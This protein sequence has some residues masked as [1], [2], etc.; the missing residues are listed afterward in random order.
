MS[1][2][3][4]MRLANRI[5]KVQP[6]LTL[7][8]AA[9]AKQMKQQGIDLVSFS[10]GEPD[11]DTPE[12]IKQKAIESL[13]SGF[14]KYTPASGTPE[15]K[16]AIAQKLAQENGLNYQPEQIIVSCGAKHSIY[17]VLQVLVNE[18]DEVIFG[19]PYWLSYPEMVTLAGGRSVVIE[20]PLESGY[21]I[22]PEQLESAITPKTKLII[23]NSPSNP[24]GAVYNRDELKALAAIAVKKNVCVLSD[25]IYEKLIFDGADHVSIGALMPEMNDLAITVNGASKAYSMTGW[26]LG[27]AACPADIAKA[28]S[29]LQSHSTSNPTSFAQVGFLEAIQHGESAVQKM[30]AEFEKRRNLMVELFS[31]IKG[32]KY[33]KPAGAFYLF[34]DISEFKLTSVEFADK[35]LDEAKVALVPGIAFGDDHAVRLSFAAS[36][37]N[38]REGIRRIGEW[39]K[40]R[41]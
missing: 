24:T 28:V 37:K 12:P 29:S 32:V 5:Q 6:S 40:S 15:L 11:F 30:K 14:T 3:T 36:E 22:K 35:L 1:Q 23:L 31:Q 18:G 26:R 33:F 41:A 17:N 19:S 34:L 8:I 25:E 4:T 38:I 9:K 21:K 7:A 20:T 13:K 10:A 27:Y 16:A 39:L 2:T